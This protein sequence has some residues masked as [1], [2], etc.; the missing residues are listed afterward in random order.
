MTI[1]LTGLN[2]PQCGSPLDVA[3][4][5]KI[6]KCASCA[7]S[8]KIEEDD[9]GQLFAS[10]KE[11]GEKVRFLQL[12]DDRKK[13]IEEKKTTWGVIENLL[14]QMVDEIPPQQSEVKGI[15][16]KFENGVT[17]STGESIMLFISNFFSFGGCLEF[18]FINGFLIPIL[19]IIGLIVSCVF[20]IAPKT[21]LFIFLGVVL[22]LQLVAAL[23]DTRQ[24]IKSTINHY[25]VVKSDFLPPLKKSYARYETIVGKI[26]TIDQ[27][28]QK[29]ESFNREKKIQ[30]KGVFHDDEGR[31]VSDGNLAIKDQYIGIDEE[32]PE[33]AINGEGIYNFNYQLSFTSVH[34]P[35][36]RFA[37]NEEG[38]DFFLLAP[39]YEE[40]GLV[41][42]PPQYYEFISS[43][44][45]KDGSSLKDSIE[46]FVRYAHNPI[47]IINPESS[48]HRIIGAFQPEVKTQ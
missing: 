40:Q 34:Y 10:L 26:K 7:S 8:I 2:C 31:Y 47:V 44:K 36:T 38:G 42:I 12:E 46:L 18:F 23:Y 27:E 25:A 35:L 39:K 15:I 19:L 16:E 9:K 48:K 32:L 20:S 5:D 37:Q 21:V 29:Y 30:W 22:V 13:L 11:I 14:N 28:I 45:N 43:I 24:Q 41:A 1:K 3:F 17:F 4:G 6:V 33:E